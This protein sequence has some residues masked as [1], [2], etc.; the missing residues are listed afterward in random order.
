MAALYHHFSSSW[1]RAVVGVDSRHNH[2]NQ[3][4]QQGQPV[5]GQPLTKHSVI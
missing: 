3:Q 5:A 1:D 4:Q 2:H